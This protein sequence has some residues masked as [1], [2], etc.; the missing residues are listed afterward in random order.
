[1]LPVMRARLPE[2]KFIDDM[3]GMTSLSVST[4]TEEQVALLRKWGVDGKEGWVSLKQT[5]EENLMGLVGLGY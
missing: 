1:M 2:R 4:D 3:P 5:V